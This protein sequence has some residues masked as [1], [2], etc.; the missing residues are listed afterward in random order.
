MILNRAAAVLATPLAALAVASAPAC[1]DDHDHDEHSHGQEVTLTFAAKVGTEAFSC[2]ATYANVGAAASTVKPNDFRFYVHDFRLVAT[3]GTEWPVSLEQDGLWQSANVALLDFE[4]KT[5]TCA[6]GTVPTNVTVRGT[7]D[8]G[9]ETVAW[10]GVK[11]RVGVPFVLNHGD[12]STAASPLNLSGLFWSWQG[13]YKF[14]RLDMAVEGAMGGENPHGDG[15]GALLHLGSTDCTLDATTQSVSA[16]GAPNRPEITLVKNATF[17]PATEKIVLDYAALVD[18]VDL[19]M[20]MGGAPG[21][22]SG[23]DDPECGPIFTHLG[24][25]LAT[26]LPSAT[27]VQTAF[28]LE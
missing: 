5:G 10:S 18:G 25:D 12:A 2:G 3:D 1:D 6:N 17:D 16:C 19:S 15:A 21:C 22:M 20:D 8:T 14:M 24:L 26:G 9:H 11:F 13:G 27:A 28:H 4:D 7:F 23:K